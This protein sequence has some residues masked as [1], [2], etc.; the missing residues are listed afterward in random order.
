MNRPWSMVPLR[1]LLTPVSRPEAVDPQKTYHILGAHWY[2]KGLY[3]KGI[4]SGSQ[5]QAKNL[6][7]AE[8]GDF[9]YNRLFAWKG[10]FAVASEENHGCYVSNEF[11]CFLV[12][13]NRID[14][15]YLWRYFSRAGIWEEAFGLS[16]GGTPTSRNRLKQDKLLAMKMPLPPVEE[17][18][19]IVAK[20][21]E[22]GAKVEKARKL[23]K[24]INDE[25]ESLIPSLITRLLRDISINRYLSDILLEDPKNGWSARCDNAE[26]GIPILTLSAVTGF[27]YREREFK[28]TSEP[29]SSSADYWLRKGD[30]LITRS[31]SLELVGHTAI[32]NGVPNPCIYPDLMM[33][34]IVDERNVEKRFVHWW[35][36][37]APVREYIQRS[38]KG[39]SPTMKKI[40]QVIVKNIPFPSS[41]LS[42][43]E[44]RR[45][46]AYLDEMQSRI[47]TLRQ[48]QFQTTNKFDLLLPSILDKAFNG[49]L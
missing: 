11:P 29:I 27:R 26:A 47:D 32:Y 45:I 22:L 6:Y 5:I 24:Q 15:R 8:Q 49:D 33:R 28:R 37:S 3:T 35:L 36:R 48:L 16:T 19:R 2:A 40:S 39:T 18:R 20:I 46:V 34:L 41:K 13:Q 17:Q 38:A 1:E 44:Q 10:S 14:S 42:P 25:T 4:K 12:N 9:V 7:R 31:N 43:T 21:E 30:L 23:R